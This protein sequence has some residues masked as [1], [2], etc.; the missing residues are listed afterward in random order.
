MDWLKKEEWK[1]GIKE[2]VVFG[3]EES[4]F[5][6]RQISLAV[7]KAVKQ[8]LQIQKG[9]QGESSQGSAFFS[10][11]KLFWVSRSNSWLVINTI[12]PPPS[13]QGASD[14]AKI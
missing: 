7:S 12:P 13:P 14:K 3:D 5:S 4:V 8:L 10:A 2:G 11:S 9:E 6:G 1:C